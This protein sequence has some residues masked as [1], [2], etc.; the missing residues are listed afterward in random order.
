MLLF[1]KIAL[2]RLKTHKL[3]PGKLL[4]QYQNLLYWINK[5]II[6]MTL[7]LWKWKIIIQ[8]IQCLVNMFFVSCANQYRI[9][10]F[11]T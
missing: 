2:H 6:G 10:P 1:V 11:L 9:Y 4:M 3:T 7:F 8:A 5:R